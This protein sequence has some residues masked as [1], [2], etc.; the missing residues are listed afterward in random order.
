MILAGCFPEPVNLTPAL[1]GGVY[2]A[3]ILRYE[4]CR[5]SRSGKYRMEIVT[6]LVLNGEH[7][8]KRSRAYCCTDYV[9]DGIPYMDPVEVGIQLLDD[10]VEACYCEDMETALG[11]RCQIATTIIHLG[12]HFELSS[13]YAVKEIADVFLD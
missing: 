1:P 5:Y 11:E 10:I 2:D 4:P 8:G 3:Q 9:G 7:Q 13:V 6:F 12:K